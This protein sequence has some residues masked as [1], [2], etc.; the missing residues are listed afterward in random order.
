MTGA[1]PESLLSFLIDV[2]V[3]SLKSRGRERAA[4]LLSTVICGK[5][6]L[7]S[8][9]TAIHQFRDIW[10]NYSLN[11]AGMATFTKTSSIGR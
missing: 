1:F 2:L 8:G 4:G 7:C 11:G 3:R 10:I 5:N 9:T 6:V